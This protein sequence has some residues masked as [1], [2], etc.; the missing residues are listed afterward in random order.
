MIKILFMLLRLIKSKD[1]EPS[2]GHTLVLVVHSTIFCQNRIKLQALWGLNERQM[3]KGKISKEWPLETNLILC[4]WME[5]KKINC[6][7]RQME[8]YLFP[9]HHDRPFNINLDQ[10]N[11]A[12]QIG[13][14]SIF[15]KVSSSFV[16]FMKLD[17]HKYCKH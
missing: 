13:K 15:L 9:K 2:L 5:K 16:W 12:F 1:R 14:R 8:N 10:V 17:F 11:H 3:K 4:H 6:T 7:N